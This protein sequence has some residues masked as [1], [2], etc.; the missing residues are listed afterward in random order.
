[1]PTG[2]ESRAKTTVHVVRRRLKVN[3]I[4]LAKRCEMVG[5]IEGAPN[6]ILRWQH[7]VRGMPYDDFPYRRPR[8]YPIRTKMPEPIAAVP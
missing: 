5:G 1:M 7:A 3:T 2:P 4:I 6:M 8:L